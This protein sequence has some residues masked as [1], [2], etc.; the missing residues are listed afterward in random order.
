MKSVGYTL[1]LETVS[2]R[3][4][5]MTRHSGSFAS[6]H[7][8]SIEHRKVQIFPVFVISFFHEQ[9]D[10]NASAHETD[11]CSHS[12]QEFRAVKRIRA[13]EQNSTFFFHLSLVS[14]K[15]GS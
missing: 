2:I 5:K 11:K 1:I 6:N 15:S 7:L 14:C 8:S 12:K 4:V 3:T 13:D 10:N 9:G